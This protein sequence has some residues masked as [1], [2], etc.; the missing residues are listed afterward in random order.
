M[1]N[2][3][4]IYM[5]NT[6]PTNTA[7]PSETAISVELQNPY[8]FDNLPALSAIQTWCLSALQADEVPNQ[9][10][11]LLRVV[12]EAESAELNQSYRQK[13]GATNVL[14]FVNDIPACMHGIPELEAELTHWGDLVIC[15][16]VVAQEAAQQ[17]KTATAHWAH[18]V[19]H[20][21]LHLQGYDHLED[22]EAERMEAIETRVL[23]NLGFANPYT[24]P[25]VPM[26]EQP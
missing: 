26:D 4:L 15:A 13:N 16:P 22:T 18:M 3:S 14:S 5:N 8:E 12:D 1:C 23:K 2:A 7:T 25:P 21:M 9:S 19:V 6:S 24:S 20:G 17:H 10:S 11:V